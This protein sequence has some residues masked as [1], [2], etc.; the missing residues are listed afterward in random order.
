[1]ITTGNRHCSCRLARVCCFSDVCD[2][3]HPCRLG[4]ASRGGGCT[5]TEVDGRCF[6]SAGDDRG[7]CILA[8]LSFVALKAVAGISIISA[9]T[10]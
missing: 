3:S 5:R 10:G 7:R 1:M 9:S 8:V 4:S 6:E 2:T